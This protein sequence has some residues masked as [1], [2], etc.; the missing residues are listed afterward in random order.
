MNHFKY[1]LITLLL[2]LASSLSQAAT[3]VG[4]VT[5]VIGEVSAMRPDGSSLPMKRGELIYAG[6]VLET[7]DGGHVH[8]RFVDGALVS[9]RP[10][11]R[12]VIEQYEESAGS[13]VA[14]KF[15]VEK[16]VV[17]SITG[18][19]GQANPEKFR[20]NTPVAAIGVRGTDFVVKVDGD[21]TQASVFT[22]AIAMSALT[23]E[24]AQ[25]LGPCDT[26]DT[27]TLAADMKG[28]MLQ[29]APQQNASPVLTPAVDLLVRRIPNPEPVPSANVELDLQVAEDAG[30]TSMF[31]ERLKDVIIAADKPIPV[32]ADKPIPVA[33]DKVIENEGRS[34]VW[35]H[36]Q[37][38]WNVP[39]HTI[40]ERFTEALGSMMQ[41][42]VGN[43]FISLYRDET[44]L[45][46]YQPSATN[47]VSFNLKSVS[48]IYQPRISSGLPPEIAQVTKASLNVDF[49][50]SA[51]ATNLEIASPKI[52]EV[53]INMAGNIDTKGRFVDRNANTSVAGALSQNGKEAGY[54]FNQAIGLGNLSGLTLWEQ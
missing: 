9:V 35:L 48:A 47:Q 19:W 15:K 23:P 26:A 36:N 49:A 50:R 20:L 37:F 30:N 40:S 6:D 41:P 31:A 44:I 10:S 54:M 32:A 34:M 16:G 3:S 51:Y 27:L 13:R 21:A 17:R 8:V 29:L 46:L 1:I 38:D 28:V 39:S 42:V 2:T 18:K 53:S 45:K 25:S 24:C 14:I 7:A 33:A 43:L 12:L 4:E 5:L 52:G 22:G 11:S